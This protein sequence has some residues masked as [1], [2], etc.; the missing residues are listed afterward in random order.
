MSTA[1]PASAA[2]GTESCP[3]CAHQPF[4]TDNFCTNCGSPLRTLTYVAKPRGSAMVGSVC[5]SLF[6]G[7]FAVLPV[8]WSQGWFAGPWATR[9]PPD[10]L[11]GL[12]IA[13]AAGALVGSM[14]LNYLLRFTYS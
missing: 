6:G 2:T 3:R 10:K 9:W 8:L 5:L 14:G 4:A 1:P 13:V 12:V 11:P 7:A